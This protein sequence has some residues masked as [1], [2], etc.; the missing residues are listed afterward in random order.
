MKILFFT[1]N[2]P[3]ETN[4]IASRVFERA[5]YWVKWGHQ[6]TVITSAPNFPEGK[7]YPGY[8]NYWHQVEWK[9]GIRIVRVKTFISRNEG[10]ILRTI[11]FIS[12][13]I[14]ALCAGLL[15]KRPDVVAA[16]S[17][18]FFV[19]VTAWL[20]AALRR[21]PFVLEIAD[22]WP[23]SIVAVGAMKQSISLRVMEKIELFLYRRANGIVA[24]TQAFKEDMIRRGIPSQKIVIIINGVDLTQF[25]P[26]PKDAALAAK[27]GLKD[28][29]VVGYIGTQ[30]SAHGL[31]NVLEVASLTKYDQEINFLFVGTG[32][33]HD[34]L[35]S[36]AVQ[37]QLDNAIFIPPQPRDRMPAFWSLCN[38]ALVHLRNNP[39]FATVIPSKMFEAMAMGLPLLLVAPKG[40][41]SRIVVQE[42]VGLWVP[43]G[44]PA[45]LKNA[46]M[47]LKKNGQLRK[48]FSDQSYAAAP[49]FSR[50]R[51]ARDMLSLLNRVLDIC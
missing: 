44:D 23:A 8:K 17:P 20:V 16:T 48:I 22:L 38:V 1:D 14:P 10:I 47:H 25:I 31:G 9:E 49:K 29:F 35:V 45:A 37:M 28:R 15:Q 4:A 24:L 18:Q 39:V 21:L 26:Q 5:R 51:Q 3:P 41:A 6:V 30:G 2:F 32:A 13:I 27:W 43:A 42:G 36:M 40:E 46:V 12:Y 11:D 33:E 19:A 50:E 34:K 7:L